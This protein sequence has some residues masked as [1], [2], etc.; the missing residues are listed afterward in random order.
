MSA[1]IAGRV[2]LAEH[3]N[4]AHAWKLWIAAAAIAALTIVGV[5]MTITL[6]RRDGA[7][8]GLLML[9]A[10]VGPAI[11]AAFGYF[12]CLPET[13]GGVSRDEQRTLLQ[14]WSDYALLGSF[15]G[16]LVA[17]GAYLRVILE[18]L[19]DISL[20]RAIAILAV[21]PWVLAACVAASKEYL[22]WAI[23]GAAGGSRAGWRARVRAAVEGCGNWLVRPLTTKFALVMGGALVLLSL[24]LAVSGDIFGPDFKGYEVVEGE[25]SYFG[26]HF[27]LGW[28]QRG[29]YLL[30][31]L[32][33]LLAL[34]GVLARGAGRRIRGSAMLAALAGILALFEVTRLAVT[35]W[36]GHHTPVV[37]TVLWLTTWAVPVVIWLMSRRRNKGGWNHTRVAIMVFYLPLF[38]LWLGFLPFVTYLAIGYGAFMAGILFMWWGFLQGGREI[39]RHL[40]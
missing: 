14:K 15:I 13:L 26:F 27:V 9:G 37:L 29:S 8:G 1:H 22:S 39:A 6:W 25:K 32:L 21:C 10:F 28:T 5:Y 3:K 18:V 31:I 12:W 40:T 2:P 17:E 36:Q 7:D 19:H 20:P 24:I 38:L 11:T 33:A 23:P 30:G 4:V 34:S 35:T 16:I